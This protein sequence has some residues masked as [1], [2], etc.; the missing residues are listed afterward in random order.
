[1]KK[2]SKLAFISRLSDQEHI[3]I[4]T[5]SKTDVQIESLLCKFNAASYID[6]DDLR[7]NDALNILEQ[8]GLLAPIRKYR[9]VN[10][11]VTPEES[12]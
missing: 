12:V 9:I 5:R 6:L 11:D 10:D 8:K 4:L 1:M 7:T 2:L 3:N